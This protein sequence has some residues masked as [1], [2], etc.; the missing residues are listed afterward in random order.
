VLNG[1]DSR[2]SLVG[3]ISA[4]LLT[5]LHG[6]AHSLTEVAAMTQLPV[7]TTHRILTELHSLGILERTFDRRF[8]PGWPLRRLGDGVSPMPAL[9]ESA[10]RVLRDLGNITQRPARVGFLRDGGITYGEKRVESDI[11][12]PANS[13]VL[14]PPHA[15]AAG[16][17]LLAFTSREV[18]ASVSHSLT[19]Y[20]RSTIDTLPKLHLAL[21]ATRRSLLAVVRS[22]LSVGECAVAAP[23]F[24]PG[25]Q[26]V[27]ALELP[28]AEQPGDFEICRVSVMVAAVS[29]TRELASVPSIVPRTMSTGRL[30]A[31]RRSQLSL[32]SPGAGPALD[33]RDPPG[34]LLD[35]SRRPW[36][37]GKGLSPEEVDRGVEP[38]RTMNRGP[39]RG[40]V[41]SSSRSRQWKGTR[42]AALDMSNAAD[43]GSRLRETRGVDVR[44][45]TTRGADYRQIPFRMMQTPDSP[46]NRGRSTPWWQD[47]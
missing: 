1:V 22:E 37:E 3:W 9:E 32:H 16:K 21:E 11:V 30:S 47:E 13:A 4:I 28:L 5:F 23:V 25:G 45:T 27:A 18:V 24:G 34:S 7:S 39:A 14:F 8:R 46:V 41:V 15:T 19:A 38:R 31:R 6:E 33:D 20:T 44:M 17:A 2:R 10:S 40:L 42:A 43:R 12:T 35:E 26:A 36:T 29:L